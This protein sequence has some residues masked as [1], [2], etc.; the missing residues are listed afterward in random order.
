MKWYKNSIHAIYAI[1]LY[2]VAF[3]IRNFSIQTRRGKKQTYFLCIIKAKIREG[4]IEF[5][6]YFLTFT[7]PNIATHKNSVNKDVRG[8]RACKQIQSIFS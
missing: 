6:A 2:S 8:Q 1:K 5:K 3:F 7:L 4:T